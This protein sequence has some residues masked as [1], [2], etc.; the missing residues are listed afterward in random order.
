MLNRAVEREVIESNPLAMLKPLTEDL[1]RNVRFLSDDEE[2]RLRQALDAR[3]DEQR[4]ERRRYNVWCESRGREP[5]PSR[6]DVEY[7]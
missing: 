7:T 2:A 1:G 5:L 6:D 3:Q 4:D